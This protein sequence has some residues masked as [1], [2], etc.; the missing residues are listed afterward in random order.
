MSVL[1][2]R[3]ALAL[4]VAA[5]AAFA[6]ISARGLLVPLYAHDLG[7]TRFEVGA[8]FSVSTFAGALLSLPS[9]LLI[10]RFGSRTLLWT[11]LVLSAASQLALATTTSVFPLF[12]WQ[13]VGGLGAGAQQASLF[14]A[15]TESVP[16]NRLGRSMGWLTFSMQAGF[17]IGPT[18]AGLLVALFDVRTVIAVTTAVLLLAVPGALAATATHQ[19]EGRLDLMTPLKA[20]F[21]QPSFV[22]VTI[23]LVS[24]TLVWGTVGAFLPIFGRESLGLPSSQV[25]F[26]LALQAVANGLARI[27]G[28]RIVDWASRRWLIVFVG[29]VVWSIATIVLGH[30]QGFTAPAVL[31]VVG[32]PFI[33]TAF[34]AIGVVFGNLSAG[35]TRGVTMG[36]YGTVLFLAL[37][38]G[39][40]LFGPLIQ[41]YGYA[42]GFTACAAASI[43]LAVVMAA[44]HAEPLRRRAEVP[45]P[46]A[47]PGT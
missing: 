1:E 24:T 35:S 41:S 21:A 42:A 45:L 31:L 40:L 29:T 34:V 32:T 19:A 13:I 28:G 43:A 9:G 36:T 16:A 17:F 4:Y 38:A 6:A 39:P 27:P 47:T 30:L 20:L 10:D 33:A 26:L 44:M 12:V 2:S 11:S 25:G 23:G 14:S 18:I 15:I 37:A 5:G 3:R 7:A 46:P 8:L 22:P